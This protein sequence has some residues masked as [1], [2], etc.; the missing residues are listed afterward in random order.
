M[1][2]HCWKQT[3]G[4]EGLGRT[5]ALSQLGLLPGN[6]VGHLQYLIPIHMCPATMHTCKC[7]QQAVMKAV[8]LSP[9]TPGSGQGSAE[10]RRSW[11]QK[12]SK[13]QHLT[14][15]P[16]SWSCS[17]S[18]TR[19]ILCQEMSHGG[20]MTLIKDPLPH[21]NKDFSSWISVLPSHNLGT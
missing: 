16:G 13:K 9:K 15:E 4:A 18:I 20:S 3:Q 5:S 7:P 17:L 8:V 12:S 6:C 21:Q 2:R 1:I 11:S 19:D 10:I 14:A